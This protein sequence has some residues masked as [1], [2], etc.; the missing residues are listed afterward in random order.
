[1]LNLPR[2]SFESFR[3]AE[4]LYLW[5]LIIPAVLFA[6]WIWRFVRRRGDLKRLRARRALPVRE[7]LGAVGD[8]AFWAALLLA[9]S[10]CIV[11]LAR[12]QALVSTVRKASADVVVLQDASA[13]MYVSDVKP[14]RWRR[15]VQFLR[16]FAETLSW[17]GDRV[18]LA[19]FAQLAAPQVRL[20][21][22][23]NALFFFIDHLGE[24]SPF[25]LE[26]ATT[27]DT[28]IEEGIRWGLRLVEKDEEVFGKNGNPKAFLVISD[29]QAW[30]GTVANALQSAR[31]MKIPVHVVGIGTST[32]GMIP[33]P[34]RPDGTRPPPVI[35]S[36]LDRASLVQLAV[37]GGGEYFEI[38][39]EPDRIVAF[40]IV[41]RLR[42]R[43]DVVKDV[44]SFDELYGRVLMAAAVVLVI[45]TA[46]LRKRTE[47]AWQAAGAL[48]VV[49]L[50]ASLV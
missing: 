18:A 1:M 31:A 22:D 30:S 15:S 6:V 26:N 44:E 20:T 38:G 48:A 21:K 34:A 11:A 32:G 12:P 50:L 43:A 45:G 28:N 49:L 35:R 9:A 4:P 42:R 27:W 5:L 13:S 16:T 2:V 3:F 8:L 25:R 46:F 47:L 39:D 24:H 17:Q 23:P 40:R 41:E 29:G 19:L 33:E 14:D 37:A 36:V 7:R 10:L